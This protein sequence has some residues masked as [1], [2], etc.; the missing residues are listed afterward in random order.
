MSD[1]NDAEIDV[2]FITERILGL[3]THTKPH[4]HTHKQTI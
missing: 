4:T 1:N 3:H 2:I